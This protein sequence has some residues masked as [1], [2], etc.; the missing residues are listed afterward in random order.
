VEITLNRDG[1][2][3]DALLKVSI[4]LAD[5]E[6]EVN[7]RLKSE[8]Q[9]MTLPGFRKGMVPLSLAKKYLWDYLVKEELEKKMET[10]IEDYFKETQI[11]Y[12]KPI[13]P[14]I[15]DKPIDLKT[16]TEFVFPYYLGIVEKF[17]IDF[18][19]SLDKIKHYQIEIEE[20]DIQ[21][22]IDQLCFTYGDTSYPDNIEDD[23]D[24][25]LILGFTELNDH[26]EEMEE[27]IKQKV[28]KYLNDFDKKLRTLLLG[29][30][31]DEEFMLNI[32]ELFKN[33]ESFR[34]FLKIE[35]LAADD[36]NARFKVKVHTLML[37]KKAELNEDLF[38]KA[39]RKEAKNEEE[40]RAEI[41]E[42]IASHNES[43]SDHML[44]SDIQEALMEHVNLKLPVVYLDKLFEE[45]NREKEIN[46]SEKENERKHFE[47]RF[48]WSL[49]IKQI[50]QEKNV[51]A[52]EDEI[53]NEAYQY[54]YT[55]FYQYG[56]FNPAQEQVEKF[57]ADFLKKESNIR[58]LN[59][60]VVTNKTLAAIKN[61]FKFKEKKVSIESFNKLHKEKHPHE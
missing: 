39:S 5:I 16:D 8:K 10:A 15:P 48:R 17:S 6:E 50:A 31:K 23:D 9:K 37:R 18:E 26:D 4:K 1:L 61:D 45:E 41:R 30:A 57:L 60:R 40:F 52:K 2:N 28:S 32:D 24:L 38:V 44:F 12:L 14:A 13:I 56:V 27:G 51:E 58:Y 21:K 53:L 7:K 54:I 3:P 33:R 42:N 47:E 29:K 19:K 35:K 34:E 11:D 49:I 36:A 20:K 59:E 22:E 25:Y 46:D 55:L 43:Q